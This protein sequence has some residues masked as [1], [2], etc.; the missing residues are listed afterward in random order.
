LHAQLLAAAQEYATLADQ[1]SARRRASAPLLAQLVEADLQ[2]V[3]MERAR[4]IVQV[5]TAPR[6][7]K[8][9]WAERADEASG[10]WTQHGAD[11]VEFLLTAN[12]GEEPKPLS[13]VASGGELSRLMLTLRAVAQGS[14]S[15]S[16]GRTQGA[17]LVFDEIDVGIGGRVAETVGRRL[18]NLAETQQ[19]LCVTHQPQLAR[20][21]DH[22]YLVEK[23][24]VDGRTVTAVGE[25]RAEA[26]VGEL[27]R[28]IGGTED[29]ATTRE[30]ARWLI[31]SARA[32]NSA[33]NGETITAQG[34]A[35]GRKGRRAVRS[36]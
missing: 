8:E 27:A 26:R 14:A 25:L 35:K 22:H 24:E 23:R 28:M 21:A 1:L 12:V 15:Q 33:E 11:R 17:T 5:E 2:H 9:A 31:E 18:K 6:G 30:T 3:A 16:S 34:K 7:L 10:Y 19:V 29:V 4:F 32:T 20:F 13:R 36:G